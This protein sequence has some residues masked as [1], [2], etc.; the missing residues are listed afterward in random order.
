[1]GKLEKKNPYGNYKVMREGMTNDKLQMTIQMTL[2]KK[3]AGFS[4]NY[5]RREKPL[6]ELYS[7]ARGNDKC[8]NGIR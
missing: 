8:A 7:Y 1:M 5:S 3:R 6:L 4:S 2:S